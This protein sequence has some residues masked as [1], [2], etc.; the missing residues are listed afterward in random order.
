[1]PSNAVAVVCRFCVQ[2]RGLGA[3]LRSADRRSA[4]LAG[5]AVYALGSGWAVMAGDCVHL[6]LA[7]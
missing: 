4:L 3:D 5:L 7:R 6:L 2:R 1:M